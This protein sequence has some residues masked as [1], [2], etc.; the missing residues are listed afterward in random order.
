MLHI[1]HTSAGLVSGEILDQAPEDTNCK[2]KMEG[3]LVAGEV[4]VHLW[5]TAEIPLSKVPNPQI[6]KLRPVFS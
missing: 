3:V 5:N 4:P 2:Q 6:F 1:V